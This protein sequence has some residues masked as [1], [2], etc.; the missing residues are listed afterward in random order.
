LSVQALMGELVD[1]WALRVSGVVAH[2]EGEEHQHGPAVRLELEHEDHS[3][4]AIRRWHVDLHAVW[5]DGAVMAV[6]GD[7]A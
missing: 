6:L 4:P 1:G 7:A 3:K 2:A 5:K